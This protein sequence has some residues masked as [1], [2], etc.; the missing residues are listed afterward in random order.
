M[1]E[2]KFLS[3]IYSIKWKIS[4]MKTTYIES[5]LCVNIFKDF[6]AL[7]FICVF[8]IFV[9]WSWFLWW[10]GQGDLLSLWWLHCWEVRH[11]Q[12]WWLLHSCWGV[13]HF[14]CWWLLP[15]A[16]GRVWH[17]VHQWLLPW[18]VGGVQHLACLLVI[19]QLW[20]ESASASAVGD[21]CLSESELVS[22]SLS[23]LGGRGMDTLLSVLTWAFCGG[24]SRLPHYRS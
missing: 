24:S 9:P 10:A 14:Q 17:L 5:H 6:M 11:L 7:S 23:L 20:G 15:R 19:T 3:E 22:D 4:C 18:S 16:V 1:F 8:I 21:S 12:S 13:W 2:C